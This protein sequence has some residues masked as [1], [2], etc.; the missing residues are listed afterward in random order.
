MLRWLGRAKSPYFV[1]VHYYDPHAPYDPP[2]PYRK[3][4][5]ANSYDGE[6]AYVDSA[7]GKLQSAIANRA[8]FIITAD[9][10][11]S[12]GE[13]GESTHGVFLYDATVRVPLLLFGSGIKQ[14]VRTDPVTLCDIAPTLLHL[15]GVT[16]HHDFDGASLL[17]ESGNRSLFAESLYAQRN[18]GYAPLFASIQQGK[19]FILA[20]EPE[21]YDLT[22]DPN[23]KLNLISKN[24]FQKWKESAQKYA[25]SSKTQ[26]ESPTDPAE[27]EKLRSLGYVGGKLKG[28]KID[29]KSKIGVIEQFNHGMVLM[30][31]QQFSAS[32]QT[33]RDLVKTDP[34]NS[35]AYRFL[36]D[37]LSAQEK[38]EDAVKAYSASIKLLP[39]PE[40]SV[41]LAKAYNRLNDPSEAETI[42]KQTIQDH[43]DYPEASFELA[44]L[45]E[46]QQNWQS[47]MKLLSRDLPDFA[48]QKGILYL[49]KNEP[50]SAV[51]QFVKALQSSPKATYW[52][53][54]GIAYQRLDR[55]ADAEKAFTNGL[56]LNPDYAELEANLS[57]LLVQLQR[58][59]DAYVHLQHVTLINPKMWGARFALGVVL[60]NLNQPEKAIK[61]Y[62]QLLSDAPSDWPQRQ[63]I[64]LRLKDLSP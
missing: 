35:L 44:S 9:H 39:D 52:N 22:A 57:F 18:F 32:E 23:E 21:F 15:A 4:F 17:A 41:Q 59:Q 63:K 38:Y 8:V 46:S 29:P 31:S 1:W 50:E 27:L 49:R 7:V 51:P 24:D 47:A 54:L 11:E 42:L 20:P 48:N 60:E 30:Y 5:A 12:L 19:K 61:V 40:V 37:N 34:E 55:L 13:H 28:S 36:G 62:Q 14:G 64:Q 10:G 56:M 58:W 26:K 2:E 33:F 25:T 53:N 6:I 45:Y 43:P 16:E 3:R